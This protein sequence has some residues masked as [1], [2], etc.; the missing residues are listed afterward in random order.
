M[1][2][3]LRNTAH[4]TQFFALLLFLSAF[5]IYDAID[6]TTVDTAWLHK[7][8]SNDLCHDVLSRPSLSAPGDKCTAI[9]VGIQI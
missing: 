4:Q 9:A 7:R 5:P 3:S 8:L 6:T 1:R 2:L